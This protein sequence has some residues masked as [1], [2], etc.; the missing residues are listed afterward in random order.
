MH[1]NG[2]SKIFTKDLENGNSIGVR[3]DPPKK[4]IPSKG[5][6]DEVAHAHKEIVPTP[7]VQNGKY[8]QPNKARGVQPLDDSGLPSNDP[9]KKHIPVG[10]RA[11]RKKG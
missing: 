10:T 2:N 6:A 3:L 5:Y 9:A 11:G 7:E 8:F 4:A 1:K